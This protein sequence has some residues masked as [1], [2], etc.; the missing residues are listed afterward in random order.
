MDTLSTSSRLLVLLLLLLLASSGGDAASFDAS[1]SSGN[2]D[3]IC[4]D[5]QWV[6]PVDV[7][8]SNSSLTGLCHAQCIASCLDFEVRKICRRHHHCHHHCYCDH[9]H[10]P[11]RRRHHHVMNFQLVLNLE[12]LYL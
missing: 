12:K 6:L 5:A 8:L 11:P 9:H 4:R 7:N 1:N 2:F 10:P 3:S